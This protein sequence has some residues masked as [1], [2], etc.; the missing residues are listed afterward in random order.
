MILGLEHL[1]NKAQCHPTTS[2]IHQ[3]ELIIRS[4][5]LLG[6][7]TLMFRV[8]ETPLLVE[9]FG[10]PLHHVEGSTNSLANALS[11]LFSI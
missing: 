6:T 2:A 11:C 7:I 3:K 4:T 5:V 1:C 9:N 8:Y 10:I